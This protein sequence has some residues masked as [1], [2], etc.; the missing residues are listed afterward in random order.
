M[1]GFL[2]AW[3]PA[4][5]Q[6]AILD[7]ADGLLFPYSMLVA[8]FVSPS[9]AVANKEYTHNFSPWVFLFVSEVLPPMLEGEGH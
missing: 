6:L 9:A 1:I 5:Q 3:N 2:E 7:H 8:N 4:I